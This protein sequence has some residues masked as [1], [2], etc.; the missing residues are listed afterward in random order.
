MN[1]V[2]NQI[3][4]NIDCSSIDEIEN[5]IRQASFLPMDEIW[6]SGNSEFPCF[7]ILVNGEFACIHYF[8]G[9]GE[10]MQSFGDYKNEKVFLAGGE[11][12]IAPADTVVSLET[13]VNCMK[14]FCSDLS[15]P[16]CIQWQEL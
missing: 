13:A 11:E 15:L 8:Y 5:I 7:G 10:M 9:D 2:T 14:E 6:I 3:Q 4:G 12:W 1:V 16:K